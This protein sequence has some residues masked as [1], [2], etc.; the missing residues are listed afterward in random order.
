MLTNHAICFKS[1]FYQMKADKKTVRIFVDQSTDHLC[2]Y[3]ILLG[4]E[5]E[6]RQR[7]A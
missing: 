3:A 7:H 5:S 1:R 2:T 6:F 4:A